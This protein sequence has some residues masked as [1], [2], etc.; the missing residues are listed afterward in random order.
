MSPLGRSLFNFAADLSWAQAES[1]REGAMS[2]EAAG[3]WLRP[4]EVALA[5]QRRQELLEGIPA[6]RSFSEVDHAL[7]RLATKGETVRP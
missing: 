3:G 6:E 2:G 1:Y 5:E 4:D 7:L